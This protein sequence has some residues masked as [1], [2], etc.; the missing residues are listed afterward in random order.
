MDK[1][2]A[3]ELVGRMNEDCDIQLAIES[4]QFKTLDDVLD[5]VK[6]RAAAIEKKLFDAGM[7]ERP[8]WTIDY[9]T[10]EGVPVK[11]N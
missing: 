6:S 10:G 8:R 7:L 3:N 5:A 9:S 4:G 1:Q 11:L 2:E